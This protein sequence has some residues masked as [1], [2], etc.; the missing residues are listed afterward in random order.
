MAGDNMNDDLKNI[1]NKA[2]DKYKFLLNNK[3]WYMMMFQNDAYVQS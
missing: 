2:N 3:K 1:F